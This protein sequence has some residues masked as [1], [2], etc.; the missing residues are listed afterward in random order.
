MSDIIYRQIDDASDPAV[1]QVKNLFKEMYAYMQDQGLMLELD[2]EGPEKWIGSVKR[3]LKRFATLQVAFHDDEAI[4]FAHGSL[5]M[6][7][8]YLGS[9]KIGVVT[10]IYVKPAYRSRKIATKL[11][12]G[13][14]HWFGGQQVHSIELQVLSQNLEA[15]NFW[16]KMGYTS[17]LFQFRKINT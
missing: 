15:M 6:T 4:G 9:R 11:L 16:R 7:P 8:D 12:E 1:G 2:H 3:T 14:E 17:E 5:G 10:H 13:L